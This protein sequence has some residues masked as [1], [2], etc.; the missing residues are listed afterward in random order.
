MNKDKKRLYSPNQDCLEII[1]SEMKELG[2]KANNSQAVNYA[3]YVLA[4]MIK[5]AK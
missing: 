4:K 2:L 1:K 5:E 3:V